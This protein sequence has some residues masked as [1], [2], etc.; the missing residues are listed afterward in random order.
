[1][2]PKLVH[3]VICQHQTDMQCLWLTEQA[4]QVG[5]DSRDPLYGLQLHP[6]SCST[7]FLNGNK[8]LYGKELHLHGPSSSVHTHMIRVRM[9]NSGECDGAAHASSSEPHPSLCEG[10]CP[11]FRPYQDAPFKKMAQLCPTGFDAYRT[12]SLHLL[13]ATSSPKR[14]L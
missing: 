7:G 9:R 10:F 13:D 5:Q 1:M 14:A 4:R 8:D 3:A 2:M 12:C 6:P 11:E